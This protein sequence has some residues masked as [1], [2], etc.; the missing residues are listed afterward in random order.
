MFAFPALSTQQG[1]TVTGKYSMD[2]KCKEES[3]KKESKKLVFSSEAQ[4][5]YTVNERATLSFLLALDIF[6][7]VLGQ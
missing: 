1:Y 6:S 2:G 5:Q 4:T 7:L 3:C